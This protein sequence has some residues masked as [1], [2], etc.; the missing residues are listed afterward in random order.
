M[1]NS[2]TYILVAMGLI[3]AFGSF[4]LF[5]DSKNAVAATAFIFV[6]VCLIA[7][8]FPFGEISLFGNK[9][10]RA[11]REIDN[12]K[13]EVL[14]NS[15]EMLSNLSMRVGRM[16]GYSLSEK[17]EM[18]SNWERLL[19]AN[20]VEPEAIDEVFR[21]RRM[22]T[23]FDYSLAILSNQVPNTANPKAIEDWEE[24]IHRRIENSATPSEIRE[25][26]DKYHLT[27]EGVDEWLADYS[28]FVQHDTHKRRREF[29]DDRRSKFQSLRLH[30][31]KPDLIADE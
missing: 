23:L 6:F 2:R 4:W 22:F 18:H 20:R 24:L 7:I 3:F 27:K 15:I 1:A 21:Y 31:E 17:E 10:K 30:A 11:V 16:S 8:D 25:Y 12:V 13:V 29:E 9:I 14:K 5:R 19:K 28:H 26:L